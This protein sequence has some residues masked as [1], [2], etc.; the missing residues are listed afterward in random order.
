MPGVAGYNCWIHARNKSE[1]ARRL[2][3][4]LLHVAPA[5][6]GSQPA[7]AAAAAEEY[8]GPVVKAATLIPAADGH[9]PRVTLTLDHAVGLELSRGQGCVKCCNQVRPPG[10]RSA[11]ARPV[12]FRAW[13][14]M[15]CAQLSALLSVADS[16][17]CTKARTRRC[18]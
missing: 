18:V 2:A 9:S 3:L 12:D 1:V 5:T 14:M 17:L 15:R 13:L 6:D 10:F 4:Q 11:M 7:I 8:S 16:D